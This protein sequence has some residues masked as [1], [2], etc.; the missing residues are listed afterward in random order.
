MNFGQTSPCSRNWTN[1]IFCVAS[2]IFTTGLRLICSAF[3][4]TVQN[5]LRGLRDFVLV[6]N[7]KEMRK[8]S[9]V[10]SLVILFLF[11]F[12]IKAQI[13]DIPSFCKG[14]SF[15]RNLKIRAVGKDVECLQALLNTDPETKLAEKGP[16]SPGN[17]T[18]YFGPLTKKAVIKFQEKYIDEV[19]AS[20]GLTKGT[21]FMG[22]TTRAKLNNLLAERNW[23][24]VNNQKKLY[25]L[26]P[27]ETN[28]ILK[29][30]QLR[31]PQKSERLK[32]LATLRI[33]TPYQLGCLGEEAGRDKDP[34]FRLDVTDC[35]AFILTTVALLNSQNLDE[36]REMMK[37]LNYRSNSE[38]TFENRLHF[39]T[40][41]NTASP[42]FRDI[43]GANLCVCKLKTKEVTLNKI[44]SDGKRLIDIDWEKKIVLKYIPNEYITKELFQNLPK[45]IGLAF[46][47]EG[48]EEIGLDIRHEGFLFDGQFLFHATSTEG[49]VVEVD[50]F[51]YYFD[52]EGNPRFDGIIFFEIK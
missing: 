49:K 34:I 10:I 36:A 3:S 5:L 20:F 16:G 4:G 50:F 9:T 37:F 28:L 8:L 23:Q 32:A 35:T 40:D 7:W 48:D 39:T 51:E 11:A 17:E 31:F 25:E 26:S 33:G 27:A 42:Y 1:I 22:I 13:V 30:I 2:P 43:T 29:E 18:R 45:A 14:I 46:I 44:K 21:G 19:L 12:D 38:I 24:W 52:K 47:K 15:E 6:I 41:R